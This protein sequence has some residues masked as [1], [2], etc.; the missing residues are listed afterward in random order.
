MLALFGLLWRT[1]DLY[2]AGDPAAERALEQLRERANALAVSTVGYIVACI[3][4]MRLTRA[5]RLADAEKA[6]I[7]CLEQGSEVGDADA[8]G[9]FGAQLAVIRWFQGGDAALADL[10]TTTAG[11]ASLATSE[12]A[13]Q[14]MVATVLARAGR[15]DE[16]VAALGATLA[17]GIDGLPRSSTW[18]TAMAVTVEAAYLLG[19]ADLAG[20]AAGLLEPFADHPVMPSLGVTC[21]GVGSRALG[22]AAMARGQTDAAVRFLERAVAGNIRIRH[23]PA[24]ALSRADLA[25]ALVVRGEPG[26]LER[27]ATL[28]GSAAEAAAA[29]EMPQ[30][31]RQWTA[32]S[33]Q[34]LSVTHA[35]V[36]VRGDSGW[37]LRAGD[38]EHQLPDLVGL[39]HLAMLLARPGQDVGVVEL[40]GSEHLTEQPAIDP[41]ALRAYR[42]RLAELDEELAASEADADIG[43]VEALRDER[44]AVVT[45]LRSSVG[46]AGR[47]RGFA[48]PQERARTATRKAISRALDAIAARDAR[49][50][51]ELRAA[52]STGSTCRF[53]PAP[54]YTSWQ[55]LRQ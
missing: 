48:T 52:V 47:I 8:T 26:D 7:A 55:V 15:A 16:A 37:V 50:G 5:G 34:I 45:E 49:L 11:S 19:D 27:A 40:I 46:L 13:F 22:L 10:V 17:G 43:R 6:A 23:R 32:R 25:E 54:G 41:A 24:A 9:Y 2:E 42:H 38:V 31:V 39:T 14:I 29:L 44:A 28:L 51:A 53:Q 18:T 21:L 30:R 3:D 35:A 1:V 4:V 33:Q 36:L 20:A 12:H